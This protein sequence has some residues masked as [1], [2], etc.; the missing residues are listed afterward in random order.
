MEAHVDKPSASDPNQITVLTI[1]KNDLQ[2]LMVTLESLMVQ[3]YKLWKLIV[4]LP[5]Q[6]DESYL[7]IRSLCDTNSKVSL[8]LQKQKGIYGAFNEGLS[9]L[10]TKLIWF[11]N[12]GDQFLGH[13][14]LETA[15]TKI[16]SLKVNLLIGGYQYEEDSTMRHFVYR[17]KFLSPRS[18]SINRRSG[19]HQSMLFNM[20]SCPNLKFD[21]SFNYAADFKFVLEFMSKNKAYRTSKIFCQIQPGGVSSSEILAVIREKQ[22]IRLNVFAYSIVDKL[23]GRAWTIGVLAKISIRNLL[24]GRFSPAKWV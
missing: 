18:F 20:E 15:V 13:K 12:G 3:S 6:N 14:S 7:T 24:S 2:G 22:E 1:S 10:E 9:Y 4:V 17:D 23:L 8:V 19:C 21:T 5:D 11:M 16:H